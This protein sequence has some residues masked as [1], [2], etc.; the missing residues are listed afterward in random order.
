MRILVLGGT[1][2][3]GPFVVQQLVAA[4]H[5]VTLFHRGKT[6]HP[7]LAGI[8]RI[9]GH[10]EQLAAHRPAF[11]ALAPEV[12]LDMF[13]LS[14]A[15]AR[16]VVETFRGLARRL[17]VVSSADVYRA[18]GVLLGLEDGP[19]DPTPLV[20][21]APLRTHLHPY[22]GA[23]PRA[24]DAPDRHLDDYDKVLVERVVSGEPALPATV[25]RL[26]MIYGPGDRQHRLHPYLRQMDAGQAAIVLG[27]AEAG[28]RAPRA[29][30]VNAAAAIALAV[31]DERACGRVYNVAEADALPEAEWVRL[32]GRAAG[33]EGEVVVTADQP[34]AGPLAGANLAQDLALNS[35]RLR[36]EL[37]YAERVDRDAALRAT[38]AWER[39]NPPPGR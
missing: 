24:A 13:A 23:E 30:V 12:V 32:V 16:G 17:V 27:R 31:T 2:F 34:P 4:G 6:E 36:A 29:Y 26:G 18:Y 10:R 21:D 3:I 38:V 1:Q 39:A 35:G 11:R 20:E 25:L 8:P 15:D 9:L 22:R 37:D 5:A 19:P 14:E 7:D 33:W 28:W